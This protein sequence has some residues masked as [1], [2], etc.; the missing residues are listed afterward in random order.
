[1]YRFIKQFA[2]RYWPYYL[3]GLLALIATNFIATVIPLKIKTAIDLLIEKQT[4]PLLKNMLIQII[5]LAIGLGITRTLSRLLIFFPG[6][7]VEHDL[8]NTLF[9]HLLG[10]SQQFYKNQ[11]IGDLISR[12]IND[13]QSLR[14]T[15]AL[16]YLH[17]INTIMM[18]SF[19]IFQ[20]TH[21]NP[22]LTLWMILPIPISMLFV[23]LF[24]KYM[25]LYT[26]QCQESLGH[27]SNFF[28]EM[29]NHIKIIKT[30]AAEKAVLSLFETKNND[31][32]TKNIKL[33]KVRA[34]MFPFIGII[35]SIGHFILL[36]IGGKYIIEARLS[37]GE[38]VA[39]STYIA[40]LSWPTASLAWI[41]NIIQR[42]KA[43]WARI[44][45]ILNTQNDF[46]GI[47]PISSPKDIFP[48]TLS[49]LSFS[50]TE[51]SPLVLK[52]ISI[53]IEKG[54]KV[55]FFGPS[56]SGK[57]TLIK[58]LS[59]ILKSSPNTINLNNTCLTH[60]CIKE[61]RKH[62]SYV[63]QHPFLFS[64]TIEDNVTF[65][66]DPTHLKNMTTLACIENDIQRFPNKHQTLVG[67]KGV[68]LS[69]GQRSR[70]AL[71]R[72]FYKP[73]SL[74]ILD[75]VLAAVDHE[76]EEHMIQNI[77][78]HLGTNSASILVSH[79]VSALTHCDMIYVFQNGEIIEHGTHKDLIKQDG[80]YNH[81]WSYQKMV[82]KL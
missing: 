52:S 9:K 31:F 51:S 48:I 26:F 11:S 14:A 27:I 20:M 44:E 71:A 34:G 65:H 35:G 81:V 78:T 45:C 2:F 40:L 54:Q 37:I 8:R 69:G 17:I 59:G 50:Y 1:M 30:T 77:N 41:I 67:E 39:L 6:R 57:S 82:E 66:N 55:G 63:S 19:V 7:F 24:V 36:I 64:T 72:A 29:F 74:L 23:G 68:V 56:G 62:I 12:M 4:F 21:I 76:T 53:S 43:A 13:I 46:Q 47:N 18:Y 70:L 79:R 32:F 60:V 61:L 10:L 42:G 28:S 15:A 33:A 16:S 5:C 49:N 58:L 3:A 75:D 25:Y 80:F 73:A 38:F 22:K